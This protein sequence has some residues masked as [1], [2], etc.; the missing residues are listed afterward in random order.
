MELKQ[1]F[2]DDVWAIIN[3]EIKTTPKNFFKLVV[4]YIFGK[5]F[6]EVEEIIQE[7]KRKYDKILS[8]FNIIENNGNLINTIRQAENEFKLEIKPLLRIIGKMN[9]KN[10]TNNH[11]KIEGFS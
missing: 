9:G 8:N 11:R 6:E 10:C 7:I 3:G 5:Q 4:Q 2:K 1:L